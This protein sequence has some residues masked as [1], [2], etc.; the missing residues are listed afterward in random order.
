MDDSGYSFYWY[1]FRY[2]WEFYLEFSPTTSR[3]VKK[4]K[5]NNIALRRILFA[6]EF[7]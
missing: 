3:K 5:L 6:H 7:I 2:G 4:I 1:M